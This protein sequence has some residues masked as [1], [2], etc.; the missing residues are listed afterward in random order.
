MVVW[1]GRE[2][3][4]G[5]TGEGVEGERE[6]VAEERGDKGEADICLWCRYEGHRLVWERDV[7]L[8]NASCEDGMEE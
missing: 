5:R 2:R 3:E 7:H 8:V 6:E 1:R 4:R